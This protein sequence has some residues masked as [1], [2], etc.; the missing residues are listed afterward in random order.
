MATWGR[1]LEEEEEEEEAAKLPPLREGEAVDLKEWLSEE[2]QTQPPNRYSEASLI[3][4][5]EENGVG[6][7]S[8]YASI[9]ST[10]YAREY[11]DRESRSLRPTRAGMEV[12]DFLVG[13][14]PDLFE[15]GFTARMEKQLD[16]IEE[17]RQ[18]W[19]D[20]MKDFYGRLDG[21]I[22][23]AKHAHIDHDELNTLFGLCEEIQEYNPP[24]KRGKKTYSDET[25]LAEMKEAIAQKEAITERQ[26]DNIRKV[27]ARYRSQISSLTDARA[28]EL[29]LTEL[30][31]REAEANLPPREETLR[32]FALMKDVEFAPPRKVGKKTYDD[33]EFL[34]SL[35]EQVEGK[36]RLTENQIRYLDRLIT[37]YAAQIPDFERIAKELG[38]E[39][40]QEEDH[41]SG[42]LLELLK[43]VQTFNEPTNRGKRTWDD[44]EFAESLQSQFQARKNLT[45]RQRSALKTM[46]GRYHAQIPQYEEKREALGLRDPNAKPKRGG[47]KKKAAKA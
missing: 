45:P 10:L 24:V 35:Q 32:K 29:G 18:G 27:V 1:G 21:W 7:P 33:K 34:G 41:E 5:L 6:R 23:E 9:V 2:K 15:V 44:A 20:L 25:F 38:M 30:I 39:H 40:E 4:A 28:D 14:L 3:K 11:V 26:V 47:R 46:L 31:V 8:T 42:P 13:R 17:G 37:K 16:D 22:E 43:E 36:R 19:T 12:N